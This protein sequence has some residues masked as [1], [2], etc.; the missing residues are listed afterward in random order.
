MNILK[1]LKSAC[2]LKTRVHIIFKDGCDTFGCILECDNGFFKVARDCTQKH[3][4][5]Y[6]ITQVKEVNKIVPFNN[7]FS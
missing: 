2:A 5:N 4:F 3:G 6:P 1:S 7:L